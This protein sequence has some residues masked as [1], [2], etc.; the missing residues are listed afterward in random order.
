MSFLL[1]RLKLFC[2]DL[3]IILGLK[4]SAAT[5]AGNVPGTVT[6]G[7]LRLRQHA[8]GCGVTGI[9]VYAGTVERLNLGARFYDDAGSV[10]SENSISFLASEDKN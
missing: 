4:K 7:T 9:V 8:S 2:Q 1:L 6:I 10:V 3:P 5:I